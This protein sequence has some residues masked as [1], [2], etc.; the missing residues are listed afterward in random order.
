[1][2][3]HL[4]KNWQ[5]YKLWGLLQKLLPYAALNFGLFKYFFSVESTFWLPKATVE[6]QI[7]D[8]SYIIED[9]KCMQI[10]LGGMII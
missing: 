1:M 8:E 6:I 9:T 5:F 2:N 10:F 4:C 7:S 3:L